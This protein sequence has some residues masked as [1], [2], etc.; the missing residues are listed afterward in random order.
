LATMN[1]S[2]AA[3]KPPA[4]SA[5]IVASGHTIELHVTCNGGQIRQR[6]GAELRMGRGG[7]DDAHLNP[8]CMGWVI[9]L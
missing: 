8:A 1:A 6:Q 3:L 7:S 9:S 5:I 2:I 4:S